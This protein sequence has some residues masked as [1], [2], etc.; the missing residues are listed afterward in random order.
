MTAETVVAV[1]S[2]AH[3]YG[4]RRA[5]DGV[6]FS[7]SRGECFG[8]LGPNGGGKTT[9]FRIL[10]TLIAPDSGKA[11]IAGLDI[12]ENLREVRRKIG[13]VFQAPALD[14]RLTVG[15]NLKHQGRLYGLNGRELAARTAS[16]LD[17]FGLADRR[18]EFVLSLSGGLRRR[19]ELVRALLH[20]PG[21]L[22]LD[23]PSTG[24]DP[25]VR[26]DFWNHLER[27]RR[28]RN[29]T[30]LLTTH[31]M[32]EADLCDRI[33][34]MDQGRLVAL[35]TPDGLK[36]RLGGDVVTVRGREPEK[37][38]L[39]LR[40]RFGGDVRLIDGEVRLERER[41]HE[42]VTGL[43][44]AFPGRFDSITVSRPTLGD[45]FIQLTGRTFS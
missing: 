42:F 1:D 3:S 41:G 40:A 7:V 38:E 13:V 44:E 5:L 8:L 37:L 39:D 15:E 33:G 29:V 34:I 21:I 20:E 14:V 9:L 30:V 17:E 28:E 2:I 6:S 11:R 25:V 43:V 45:V 12:R 36:S 26:R 35:D 32:D 19:V 31:L 16:L 24:L 23:E 18:N 4:S 22:L 27:L 10:S